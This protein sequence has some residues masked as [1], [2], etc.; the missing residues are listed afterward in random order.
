[1]TDIMRRALS[2][3]DASYPPELTGGGSAGP[4]ITSIVPTSIPT[5]LLATITV[6]GRG[7]EAGSSAE[8]DGLAQSTTFVSATE[9]TFD[10]TPASSGLTFVSI[11]NVDDNE[12]NSVPLTVTDDPPTVQV[13]AEEATTEAEPEPEPEPEP[14]PEDDPPT[15]GTGPKRRKPRA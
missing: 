12:S 8:V 13:E 9:L 10:T 4:H 14:T 11:R 15:G 7:F 2:Y 6:T 5:A 1:M 3:Y